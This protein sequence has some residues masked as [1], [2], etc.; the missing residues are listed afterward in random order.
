MLC[1]DAHVQVNHL[2]RGQALSPAFVTAIALVRN[3]LFEFGDG[4]ALSLTKIIQ[5]CKRIEPRPGVEKPRNVGVS[6]SKIFG[7]ECEA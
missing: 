2:T 4:R 1:S 7:H 6:Q 5:L 3:P